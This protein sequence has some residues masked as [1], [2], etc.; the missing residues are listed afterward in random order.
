MS[1]P[2]LYLDIEGTGLSPTADR[3]VELALLPAGGE[4]KV[5]RINP[6]IPIPAEATAVHGITDQDVKDCPPFRQFAASVQAMVEGK[7]L[8]GYLLRK[9]DTIMLDAELRRAGQPGIARDQSGK[10]C[11]QEIDLYE[12]WQRHEPRTLVG[13]AARFAGVDL[14]DAHS[15]DADT[16]VLPEILEGMLQYFGLRDRSSSELVALCIPDGEVDRDRKFKRT[17]DGVIVFNFTDSKGQPVH[18][19]AGLLQWILQ[20]D[21]SEETK[22]YARQFLEE[23][24]GP[25]PAAV[26]NSQVSLGV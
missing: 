19:N 9:Y 16:E 23:I 15:A 10:L 14:E 12:I 17:E 26:P 1:D 18:E 7:V 2:L 6:G 13:A 5:R 11:V 25:P 8:V 21:F 24:Y 4:L 20:K 3:I 22:A